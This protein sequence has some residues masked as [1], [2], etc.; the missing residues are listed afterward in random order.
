MMSKK[1]V[2]MIAGM[3]AVLII[4]GLSIIFSPVLMLVLGMLFLVTGTALFAVGVG[5]ALVACTII[6]ILVYLVALC[7]LWCLLMIPYPIILVFSGKDAAK[8]Y[9]S[10]ITF[11]VFPYDGDKE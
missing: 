8:K 9:N 10:D 6:A 4:I 2:N 3:M 11:A 1:T 5:V 7:L